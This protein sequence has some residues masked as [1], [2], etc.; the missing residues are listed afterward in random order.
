MEGYS[1]AP[2]IEACSKQSARLQEP[3]T[4]QCIYC[5][6]SIRAYHVSTLPKRNRIVISTMYTL[7]CEIHAG[8]LYDVATYT[9][10]CS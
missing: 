3:F 5:G 7:L 2:A 1:D 8:I 4:E 9:V 6:S 10:W